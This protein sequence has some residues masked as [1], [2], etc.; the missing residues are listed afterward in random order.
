MKKL[1]ENRLR[2]KREVLKESNGNKTSHDGV[3]PGESI[4]YLIKRWR[5]APPRSP[6]KRL[7][8]KNKQSI[9]RLIWWKGRDPISDERKEQVR[10]SLE[11]AVQMACDTSSSSSS[12]CTKNDE[13]EN[14]REK[15]TKTRHA[16]EISIEEIR[17]SLTLDEISIEEI[18]ESLTSLKVD[19]E[20][21]CSSH[22]PASSLSSIEVAIDDEM[23]RSS[24][25]SSRVKKMNEKVNKIDTT[26]KISPSSMKYEPEEQ[27]GDLS[28]RNSSSTIESFV[29]DEGGISEMIVSRD[30]FTT[31]KLDEET[32]Q[33][34]REWKS[35]EGLSSEHVLNQRITGSERVRPVLEVAKP[36]EMLVVR[37]EKE[38]VDDSLRD[39]FNVESEIDE[40]LLLADAEAFTAVRQL[41]NQ[42]KVLREAFGKSVGDEKKSFSP[43]KSDT[44]E[45]WTI[46]SK[47]AS[48]SLE[49]FDKW[50]R[51]SGVK[52]GL[53]ERSA[54]EAPETLVPDF[55][56]V[57]DENRLAYSL[58][59]KRFD[60]VLWTR[61]LIQTTDVPCKI[62]NVDRRDTK[63]NEQTFEGVQEKEEK[64]RIEKVKQEES[65]FLPDLDEDDDV[66][67][68]DD[69]LRYSTESLESEIVSNKI[70]MSLRERKHDKRIAQARERRDRALRDQAKYA[71]AI[72][73][74]RHS[75]SSESSGEDE[76]QQDQRQ[77][78]SIKSSSL[79]Q[80]PLYSPP[81]VVRSL[82][83]LDE[84][85]E[86]DSEEQEI[87][88]RRKMFDRA[89]EEHDRSN[90]FDNA[91]KC[92]DT[93]SPTP[94]YPEIGNMDIVG[95]AGS[96]STRRRSAL[97]VSQIQ[98]KT[99]DEAWSPRPEESSI[100]LTKK[101]KEDPI[102]S[103]L[104]RIIGEY[105]AALNGRREV[106]VRRKVSAE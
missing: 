26:R 17:Q 44:E 51:E 41:Q 6:E 80:H 77:Q 94:Q 54:E 71:A 98:R 104:E 63:K 21:N 34:L 79:E 88:P 70:T 10:S 7:S 64:K 78:I 19:V 31:T 16:E 36:S 89:W 12:N 5:T 65:L 18:R 13:N 9:K 8:P 29:S 58:P 61:T 93:P 90:Q 30:V 39:V 82:T 38:D 52:G 62:Q 43:M 46:P 28:V 68:D 14:E 96:K 101:M 56:N 92:I 22:T 2:V 86:N 103:A 67:L 99:F 83:K 37:T 25:P 85:L 95:E 84:V 59:S 102:A 33:I 53:F 74:V 69:E 15:K 105:E 40:E 50:F 24:K 1:S 47:I 66:L 27:E 42:L 55:Q 97:A 57:V 32:E 49:N 11:K 60:K 87:T 35:I 76:T 48:E 73:S 23:I 75:M 106:S 4:S 81:C 72:D 3:Q 100:D 45:V 20:E 91:W